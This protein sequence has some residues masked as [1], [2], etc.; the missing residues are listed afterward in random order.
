[1]NRWIDR[2]AGALFGTVVVA[3]VA[4]VILGINQADRRLEAASPVFR[5]TYSYAVVTLPPRAHR[6]DLQQTM[7]VYGRQGY[8]YAYIVEPEVGAWGDKYGYI[9]LERIN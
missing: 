4:A 2:H 7:N 6:P 5:V 3:I 1:M 8:R 9:I